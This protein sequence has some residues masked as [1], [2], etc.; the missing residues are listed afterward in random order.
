MDDLPSNVIDLAREISHFVDPENIIPQGKL[1]REIS[2]DEFHHVMQ[3]FGS[4]VMLGAQK[5]QSFL[6]AVLPANNK[7]R[8][9]LFDYTGCFGEIEEEQPGS[10]PYRT[11]DGGSPELSVHEAPRSLG[12]PGCYHGM[13]I[14]EKQSC[15]RAERECI[16]L[17]VANEELGIN[18]SDV[19]LEVDGLKRQALSWKEF[20]VDQGSSVA[21]LKDKME[22]L[23]RENHELE[24]VIEI[25]QREVRS[26]IH[27]SI[28]Y[29]SQCTIG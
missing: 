16:E 5:P 6:F 23:V 20:V 29:L 7:M 27:T 13:Y 22:K 14:Q 24:E 1:T 12:E 15:E 4:P 19:E 17:R 2:P 21:T 25:R 9:T 18:L 8:S 11:P 10:L 26:F 28:K 3:A